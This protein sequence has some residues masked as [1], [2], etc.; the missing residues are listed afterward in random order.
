[1]DKIFSARFLKF[2]MVGILGMVVDFSTTWLCKETLKINKYI[3]NSTGFCCALINNYL[4]NRYWTFNSTTAQIAPQFTKFLLVSL[5]GLGL[6]NL[7]LYLFVRNTKYNFYFLKLCVTGIV[8]FWNYF[9]NS[10]YTFH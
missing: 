4:L 10:L 5:I 7:L 8:F 1:M 3:A 6:N 2:G 9:A